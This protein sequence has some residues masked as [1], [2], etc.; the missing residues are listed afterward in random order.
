LLDSGT[1]GFGA[2]FFGGKTGGKTLSGAGSGAAI[3]Y[4]PISEYAFEEAIA[5]ALYGARDARDLNEVDPGT[6]QHDA[7]VAQAEIFRFLGVQIGLK[8]WPQFSD[9]GIVHDLTDHGREQKGWEL[10]LTALCLED[11]AR[12]VRF[13]TGAVMACGGFVLSR[14]FDGG[15]AAAIE[16]EFVRATCVEMYSVLIASGLELTAQSHLIMSTLCQCTRETL[17]ATAG[18]PVRVE[19]IIRKSGTL[20]RCESGGSMAPPQVA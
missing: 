14:R 3:G 15:E 16:F 4:F 7:T 17:E 1:E 8:S 9:A 13:L 10:N 11:A 2:G 6:D 18:D 20:P 5:V 12:T 19:L